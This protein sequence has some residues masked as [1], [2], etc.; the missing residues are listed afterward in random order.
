MAAGRHWLLPSSFGLFY[1]P[2]FS[3]E[4]RARRLI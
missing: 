2:N 1:P 4:D 3:T